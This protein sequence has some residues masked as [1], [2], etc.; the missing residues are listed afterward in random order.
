MSQ[1]FDSLGTGVM[2]AFSIF[3]GAMRAAARSAN[4]F[5]KER[6]NL[7]GG[8][9]TVAV[10]RQLRAKIVGT[11][12]FGGGVKI[13]VGINDNQRF[14]LR[15]DS[16][17]IA[18]SKPCGRIVIEFNHRG[19]IGGNHQRLHGIPH[20]HALRFGFVKNESRR[21]AAKQ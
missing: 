12:N 11:D 4:G 19:L 6:G 7:G 5:L 2:S 15:D 10:N 20:I 14:R 1:P 9:A 18:A 13:A 8:H 3:N 21:R 17:W 16:D